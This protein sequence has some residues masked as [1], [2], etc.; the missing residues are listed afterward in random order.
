MTNF[1]ISVFPSLMALACFQIP[2]TI[3]QTQ[4]VT[5]WFHTEIV[6]R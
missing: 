4:T 3:H 6:Q 5:D 1:P 2:S